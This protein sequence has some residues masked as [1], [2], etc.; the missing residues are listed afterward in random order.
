[1]RLLPGFDQ[2]VLGPGT[3]DGRVVPTARRSAVSRQAG[4][5]SPVVV[6]GGV[7]RGTWELDGDSVRIGW[8]REAGKV[9]RRAVEAEVVRLSSI[10]GRELG[11]EISRA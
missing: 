7:V 5:I 10:V 8:F 11:S 2:Y 4:W 9:P 6:A 3:A 1:V